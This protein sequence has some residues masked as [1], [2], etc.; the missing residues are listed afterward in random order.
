VTVPASEFGRSKVRF[1]TPSTAVA[2]TLLSKAPDDR[3]SPPILPTYSDLDGKISRDIKT[4][5]PPMG[6]TVAEVPTGA[7]TRKS[8]AP[9]DTELQKSRIFGGRPP[10]QIN[11]SQGEI[12]TVNPGEAT[13]PRKTGAVGRPIIKRDDGDAPIRQAPTQR[14]E[15]PI[16]VPPTRQRDETQNAPVRVPRSDPP[17][18]Q[19]P[20]SEPIRK[21][22]YEPPPTRS[23][24]T[25]RY[26]PPP[27]RSEPPPRNVPAPRNDPPPTKSDPP[28]TKSEPSKPPVD[29]KKDGA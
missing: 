23:E 4:V 16:Y 24:P 9:L 7:T 11:T 22:R 5:R 28:P 29:R 18:D 13:E 20:R 26:D 3:Q 17:A 2:K 10:L 21:P 27:T 12:K 1:G 14:Q 19:T 8:D 6:R 15:T 25:P